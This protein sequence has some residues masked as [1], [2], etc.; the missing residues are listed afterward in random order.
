MPGSTLLR[1]GIADLVLPA[2]LGPRV[3]TFLDANKFQ[4]NTTPATGPVTTNPGELLVVM[5]GSEDTSSAVSTPTGNSLTYT[6][7]SSA[8]AA[9][10]AWAGIW[11]AVDAAGGS[12]WTLSAARGA[13]VKK[14][15]WCAVTFPA[16]STVGAA[17]T[18]IAHLGTAS[19]TVTTTGANSSIVA[20]VF[21]WSVQSVFADWAT[22]NGFHPNVVNQGELA[23]IKVTGAVN[24]YMAYYPDV[25]AAGAK[26]V[27]LS[28]LSSNNLIVAQEIIA[29]PPPVVGTFE[30]WGVPI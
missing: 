4:A 19:I 23:R 28:G 12:A 7:R 22:I 30:G 26:T 11:T 1:R 20:A 21:D 18:G 2:N 29:A 27:S 13:T 24:I 16:G 6:L 9:S 8:T 3:A 17:P 14:F 25:G 10:N 15:G 5:A